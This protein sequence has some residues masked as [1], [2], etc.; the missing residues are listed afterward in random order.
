MT[1][2]SYGAELNRTRVGKG[3]LVTSRSGLR[4]VV[5]Y[6]VSLGLGSLGA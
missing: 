2:L 4:R 3:S 5:A 6:T 1:S